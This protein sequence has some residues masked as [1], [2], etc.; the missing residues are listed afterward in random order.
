MLFL[1]DE[2]PVKLGEVLE[3]QTE[4]KAQADATPQRHSW[5]LALV[6]PGWTFPLDFLGSCPHPAWRFNQPQCVSSG[7]EISYQLT[8]LMM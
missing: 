7:S 6:G 4:I 8:G 2:A 3:N 5:M 1:T